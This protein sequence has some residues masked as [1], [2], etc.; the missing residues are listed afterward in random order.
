MQVQG[1]TVK[2]KVDYSENETKLKGVVDCQCGRKVIIDEPITDGALDFEVEKNNAIIVN[3]KIENPVIPDYVVLQGKLEKAI[4]LI[5]FLLAEGM[6]SA[7]IIASAN[8]LK[9]DII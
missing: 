6:F 9:G 1:N 2:L 3:E 7:S 8:N 5:D 4:G